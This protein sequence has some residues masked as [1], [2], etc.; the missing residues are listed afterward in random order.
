MTQ[1]CYRCGTSRHNPFEC[2]YFT[3]GLQFNNCGRRGHKALVCCQHRQ[4]GRGRSTF[5]PRGSAHTQRGSPNSF[6]PRRVSSNRFTSFPQRGFSGLQQ[7]HYTEESESTSSVLTVH[8]IQNVPPI[9]YT[10][11]VNGTPISMEVDLGSCYSLLNSDWWNRLGR[12]VLRRGPILKDVSRNIIPVLGIANVEVRLNG[13]FRQLRVVFLDRT[14]TASLFGREWIAEF[15]LL[16]VHQTEP[17]QVPN[18]LTSLLTEYS[19]LFD[20]ATLPSIKKFKAHLHIKPNSNFKLFKPR[21][22]PYALR[23]KVEAELEQLESFGIIS[24]V[25]TAEFSTTPIVSVP[26]PSGQVRICGDFKVSV[27]QYLDLTQ[28]PLPHIEEVFERLTGGQVYSKL[29]LPDA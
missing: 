14:D 16:S 9:Q 5:Q 8:A 25:E 20:T 11:E 7:S 18:S 10:V 24:K 4:R 3:K 17:E 27:N 1:P 23:P 15:H 19:D 28:Y 22:V 26:K 21:P 29:Y 12:P 13:Q 6:Q 2:N